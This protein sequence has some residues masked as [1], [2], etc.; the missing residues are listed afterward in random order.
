[1]L[2]VG[3]APVPAGDVALVGAGT[4]STTGADEAVPVGVGAAPARVGV[5]EWVVGATGAAGPLGPPPT[6]HAM[7][8]EAATATV[9]STTTGPWLRAALCRPILEVFHGTAHPGAR[10]SMGWVSEQQKQADNRAR[11]TT[12]EFRAFVREGWAPRGSEVSGPA[13]AAAHAA[14][15]RA[16]LS[17]AYPR[18]RLVVPAG[19]LK[20][21]SN[22]TDY[23]F[24]PHTAFAWLTGL[25]A[26]REPDAVLV[27]E[28]VTG[29]DGT[30]SGHEAVLYFR[31]LGER[32][33][34]EFFA[35]ARYGEFWVGA[36][37]TLADVELELGITARHIDEFDA[38]VAKDAGEVTVRLVRDADLELTARLDAARVENGAAEEGLQE[39]DDAL[40][41]DISHLRMRKDDHEVEQM[42]AAVAATHHGFEAMIAELQRAVEE[43]RGE[44]W[45][46]GTFGLHARHRGNGVG[47]D[48]ICAAGDHA[49]TLHWIKNTGEVRDGDLVLIDAGVEVDS[50]YT[51]DITRTLPVSGTFTD[52]QREVYDAVY[53][54]Q[55][56]GIAAVKPGAKFSDV[57]A[58]AIRVIAEQLHAWGLLPEGVSVEDTLDKEHGQYHRRWMVHGTSHHLGLDVHDCA[59]ATREEYMDAVLEP[60]MVLTVEPGL[61]FKA[62]DL[63]APERFRG[64]GVRIEDDVV[65]TED[66]CEN[67][68]AAMPRSSVD[69]EAWIARVQ[70]A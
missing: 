56:A 23:V 30:A 61:Y 13:P 8:A 46:E 28:P 40:A 67:L 43:G 18:Q 37:P 25:G 39:S 12:D 15:R 49:N 22:D 7:P 27:L 64:I 60:G 57:H 68:S 33:S 70:G 63:L 42:R 10:G 1:M 52:A 53:A 19:G 36:R 11:A 4:T 50:L 14:A 20:V 41:H 29:D 6:A 47:Y 65:V 31:P 44:R 34:D 24:R 5:A 48:S 62:D 58:A 16:V 2:V 32:D 21:R 26:D 59:L 45:L 66:G 54:A 9:A 51:A 35:D 17:A 55:E 38:A 3:P 69:V